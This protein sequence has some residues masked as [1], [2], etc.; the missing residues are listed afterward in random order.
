VTKNALELVPLVPGRFDTIRVLPSA[1]DWLPGIVQLL[2]PK[3]T[4]R[5]A[6]QHAK[7]FE[8]ESRSYTSKILYSTYK[9]GL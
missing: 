8:L 1:L 9:I 5:W 6:E 4:E 3:H 2:D 7:I